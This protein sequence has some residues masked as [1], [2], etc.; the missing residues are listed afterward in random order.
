[1]AVV[2]PA[3]ADLPVVEGE[4]SVVG[5]GDAVSVAAE[6][7]EDL[8]GAGE[9][10]LGVDDPLGLAEGPEVAGEGQRGG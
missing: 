3:E 2:A 5:D 10:G 4:E 1:M 6:V 7:V 8:L 9:G